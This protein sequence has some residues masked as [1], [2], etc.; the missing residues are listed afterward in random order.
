VTEES[1]HCSLLLLR[2]FSSTSL[3][4]EEIS[5]PQS[6]LSSFPS[7]EAWVAAN[8]PGHT[9]WV[10]YDIDPSTCHLKECFSFSKHGWLYLDEEYLLAKLLSLSF[11]LVPESGRKRIGPPPREGNDVRALWSPP[12]IF[13]G[14]KK[15]KPRVEVWKT[16][17]PKDHSKL[18]E[19]TIEL[20]FDTEMPDFPFPFWTEIQ[21]PHYAFKLRVVDAGRGLSSP[22]PYVPERPPEF[23]GPIKRTLEGISL[24]LNSPPYYKELHLFATD[25]AD[26]AS[27]PIAIPCTLLREG[28]EKVTVKVSTEN[29]TS[30]LLFGHRYRWTVVPE[31]TQHVYVEMDELF[32]WNDQL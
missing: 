2:L 13:N 32:L 7:W 29:L 8:A 10:V 23:I 26:P 11:S 5:A 1:S 16:L 4:L 9:S 12:I 21:S 25:L 19:C 18:S 31:G 28:K 3:L 14:K 30:F 17:W 15:E 22:Q 24:S 27:A 6:A 20:Y